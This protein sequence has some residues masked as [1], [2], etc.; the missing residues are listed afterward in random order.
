MVI[1]KVQN[2]NLIDSVLSYL[3]VGLATRGHGSTSMW[4]S[5]NPDCIYMVNHKSLFALH[6][7]FT[8]CKQYNFYSVLTCDA[9][10]A[11]AA[12]AYALILVF[13]FDSTPVLI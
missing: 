10:H 3:T 7:A 9:I 12:C 6:V 2:H 5:K 4:T 1:C 11:S 8:Q 13:K